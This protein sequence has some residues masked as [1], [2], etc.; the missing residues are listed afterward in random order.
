MIE[1]RASLMRLNSRLLRSLLSAALLA[2][3]SFASLSAGEIH[4]QEKSPMADGLTAFASPTDK[5]N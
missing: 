3:F 2:L 4:M 5:S 1:M